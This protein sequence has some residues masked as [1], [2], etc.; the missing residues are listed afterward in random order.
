LQANVD[1]NAWFGSHGVATVH[2]ILEK[3]LGALKEEG[4]TKIGATGYCYGGEK[5][6]S[7]I[8]VQL[9]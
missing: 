9:L 1:I 5:A 4:A 3:V 8:H 6:L 2:P 7:P